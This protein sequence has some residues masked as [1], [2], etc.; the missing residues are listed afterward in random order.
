[1]MAWGWVNHGVSFIFGWTISLRIE[2]KTF[3][4]SFA[5]YVQGCMWSNSTIFWHKFICI[6][7][8]V[9]QVPTLTCLHPENLWTMKGQRKYDPDCINVGYI[10]E[11]RHSMSSAK[12][13][14]WNQ[15]RWNPLSIDDAKM[16]CDQMVRYKFDIDVHTTSIK[17][18]ASVAVLHI[19]WLSVSCGL[20]INAPSQ[21]LHTECLSRYH[22][23]CHSHRKVPVKTGQ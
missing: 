6:L 5:V 7:V 20:K 15:T 8:E 14:S 9:R 10:W 17:W 18:I 1:M 13:G 2:K 16:V 19:T 12:F 22:I 23:K 11:C 21:P 3:F 4:M